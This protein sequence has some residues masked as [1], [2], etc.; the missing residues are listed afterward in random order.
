MGGSEMKNRS[1][2]IFLI[3]FSLLQYSPSAADIFDSIK[4]GIDTTVKKVKEG[5]NKGIDKTKAC[6]EVVALG[7]EWAAKQGGLQAAKGTLKAA[8]TLQKT[9]PRLVGLLTAQKAATL[10]LDAAKVTLVAAEKASEGIAKAT[11][12][13]GD[14]ASKGFSVDSITFETTS[15]DLM[16]QKPL[17]LHIIGTIAG[18]RFNAIVKDI[19]FSNADSFVS[20]ILKNLNPF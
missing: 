1:K 10:A 14:I 18:K 16:E 3:I 4:K 13:V 6:A 8:E 17:S 5:V 12:L 2:I 15:K 7:T 20:S 11:K 19:N 9:D